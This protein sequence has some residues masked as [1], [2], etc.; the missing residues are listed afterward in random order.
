MKKK[1]ILMAAGRGTRLSREVKN[2]CK[3]T[4]D[5]GDNMPLIRYTVQ[6]L[7]DSGIEP[8]VVVGY[9]KQRVIAALEGLPV[10]FHENIFYSIT[11][12]L[13]S[14]WFARDEL[15]GDLILLGNADVYW[16]NNLLSVLLDE[17]K[18]CVMLS[19]SSRLEQG[20]YLLK[21]ENDRI[22]HYGKGIDCKQ[23]NCEYV[24]LAA[25][26]GD[27]IKKCKNRLEQMVQQQRHGDWWEQIFYSMTSE[28]SIWAKDIAGIFWEEID[29]IEDYYR[30]LEFRKNG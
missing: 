14:L 3:C 21:V 27:M 30:I 11:N 6:M 20:D 24:G 23:A 28:R 8:H 19:D 26:R 1:A 7:C 18:D 25:I 17:Q 29:Y 13:V 2:Y 22:I 12:S 9:E 4:L 10:I 16:E 5:I 15:D